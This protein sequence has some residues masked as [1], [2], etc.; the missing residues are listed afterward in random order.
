MGVDIV[1]FTLHADEQMKRRGI[2][3]T[4]VIKALKSPNES[5]AVSRGPT[6]AGSVET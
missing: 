5:I 3:E 2:T 4:E 6:D 1:E